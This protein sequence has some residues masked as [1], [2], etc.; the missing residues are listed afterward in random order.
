MLLVTDN[1]TKD[2]YAG[3]L[4]SVS[5]TSELFPP[6]SKSHQLD[7]L[8]HHQKLSNIGS[9]SHWYNKLLGWWNQSILNVLSSIYIA[10]IFND[11]DYII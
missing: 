6:C 7:I 3:T 10:L 9:I 8:N 4:Y 5:P 11:S 2:N 1:L